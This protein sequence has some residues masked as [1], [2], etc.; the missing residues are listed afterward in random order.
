MFRPQPLFYG[1]MSVEH[2]CVVVV[3]NRIVSI[4]EGFVSA[5]NP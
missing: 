4:L 1:V 5:N 3:F 2:V